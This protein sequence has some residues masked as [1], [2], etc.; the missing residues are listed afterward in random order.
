MIIVQLREFDFYKLNLC[1]D[2]QASAVDAIDYAYWLVSKCNY[3]HR[4]VFDGNKEKQFYGLLAQ[5]AIEDLL[6][7]Q[8]TRPSHKADGGIDIVINNNNIDIKNVIRN[9]SPLNCEYT[10]NIIEKQVTQGLTDW[11]LLTSFNKKDNCLYI[12]G[13]YK[14]E[15]LQFVDF[16][17]AG[18]IVKNDW[19]KDII[20]KMDCFN[21]DNYLLL[22]VNNV[23]DLKDKL[24]EKT[25]KLKNSELDILEVERVEL[26]K[27][28][29]DTNKE[30]LNN[31]YKLKIENSEVYT[32]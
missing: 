29:K 6:G 9:S 30:F 31:I 10:N 4:G 20:F 12:M 2:E 5:V 3:G 23:E 17:A 26:Y 1:S 16:Y 15:W 13:Y 28:Y 11:Y 14:K 18:D 25:N 27:L 8:R 7:M 24:P 21:V 32:L 19:G 22:D